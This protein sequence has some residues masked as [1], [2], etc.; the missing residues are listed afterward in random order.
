MGVFR[1]R[2]SVF[3]VVVAVILFFVAGVWW[4][5][6]D[7]ADQLL[8]RANLAFEAK[9][10]V[11]CERLAKQILAKDAHHT[12]ASLLLARIAHE[13]KRPHEALE[14]LSRVLAA[15]DENFQEAAFY[16]GDVWLF[17]LKQPAKAEEYYRRVL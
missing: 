17:D 12:R 6:Q 3:S 14:N 5:K 13:T 11:E 2:R 1:R 4:L 8:A 7:S 10:F 15:N 9:Q 16:T